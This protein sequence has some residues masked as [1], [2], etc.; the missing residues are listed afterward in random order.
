MYLEIPS[1][2]QI[3]SSK[4]PV[5]LLS[6]ASLA[7]GGCAKMAANAEEFVPRM[8]N[9]TVRSEQPAGLSQTDESVHDK[10]PTLKRERPQ[11]PQQ[12]HINHK[13]PKTSPDSL[14]MELP[15]MEE[16]SDETH[17]SLVGAIFEIGVQ[18]ASP[19]VIADYMQL[20]PK[21]L[22]SERIKSHLQKLRQHI[23]REKEKFLEEYDRVVTDASIISKLSTTESQTN[24]FENFPPIQLRGGGSAGLLSL[25][26]QKANRDEQSTKPGQTT[27]GMK[28]TVS[29]VPSLY[30]K[31][32]QFPRMTDAEKESSLGHSLSLVEGLLEHM[33][34]YLLEQRQEG[35][36]VIQQ[37]LP[38]SSNMTGQES[39]YESEGSKQPSLSESQHGTVLRQASEQNAMFLPEIQT[40]NNAAPEIPSRYSAV[41]ATGTGSSLHSNPQI[42]A[43]WFQDLVPFVMQGMETP[44]NLAFSSTIANILGI[45]EDPNKNKSFAVTTPSQCSLEEVNKAIPPNSNQMQR[46]LLD[47]AMYRKSGA[48]HFALGQVASISSRRRPR[49][50]SSAAIDGFGHFYPVLGNGET[51]HNARLGSSIEDNP[52][53]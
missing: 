41:M 47:A 4:V 24:G 45:S 25:L 29:A 8:Q 7:L 44:G 1:P 18:N 23:G 22:T 30:P 32:I 19:S 3:T 39:T 20:H 27:R 13:R 26:V 17:R 50:D 51:P 37:V 33:K 49:A 10:P 48:A 43:C 14:S 46:T 6:D 40:P 21:Q 52:R 28:P 34:K 53:D 12:Q 9:V 2:H 11:G 15:D 31:D 16:W 35:S 42:P 5:N 36:P 38:A